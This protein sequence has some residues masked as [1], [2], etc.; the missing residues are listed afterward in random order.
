MAL[1]F[2]FGQSSHGVATVM[3]EEFVTDFNSIMPEMSKRIDSK[4]FGVNV[5]LS[6]LGPQ[7]NCLR[8][9]ESET[10]EK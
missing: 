4:L 3:E 6:L 9:R 5:D 8:L 2:A 7:T 10:M 1:L